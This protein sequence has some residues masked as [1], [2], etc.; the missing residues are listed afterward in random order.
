MDDFQQK[1]IKRLDLLLRLQLESVPRD[2][3]SSI[4]QIVHRL[5]DY[6]L[7]PAEVSSIIGKPLNYITALAS[8]RKSKKAGV[9]RKAK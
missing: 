6:G 8:S 4:T 5:L 3:S 9:K 7:S 1:L 2:T